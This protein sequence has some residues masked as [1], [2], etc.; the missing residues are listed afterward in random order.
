VFPYLRPYLAE[1]GPF[2]LNASAFLLFIMGAFGIVGNVGG[3]FTLDRF[4]ARGAIFAAL[5]A[6][7]AI[8]LLMR[9]IHAPLAAASAL[10]V[11]WGVT[12]WAYSPSVNHALADAA[13]EHRDVALALNMTAFNLGITCG[14]AIGGAIIA[15]SGVA[16]IVFAGA[17]LLAVALIVAYWLPQRSLQPA[18]HYS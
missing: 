12:S 3:G 5:G 7:L 16:N 17:G 14:S 1:T 4:G 13:G 2:D 9:L 15:T 8:F 10:F 18:A 6:N 11:A